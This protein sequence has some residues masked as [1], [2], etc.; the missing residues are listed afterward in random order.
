MKTFITDVTR[1][2]FDTEVTQKKELVLVD[3]WAKWCGP[4]RILQPILEDLAEEYAGRVSIV[5]VDVDNSAAIWVDHN[6][7]AIPTV[8]FFQNGKLINN[9]VGASSKATYQA[10]IDKHLAK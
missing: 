2:T 4:C 9:V 1:E 7:R 6:V 3:F 10:I 5:R 8:L